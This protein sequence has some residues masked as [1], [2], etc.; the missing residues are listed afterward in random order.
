[1]N[2]ALSRGIKIISTEVG[3]DFN[4]YR[5]FTSSTVGELNQFLTWCKEHGIGNTVW[6]NENLTNWPTYKALGLAFP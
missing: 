4:E 1:M 6:M 2:T 5:S 3:A